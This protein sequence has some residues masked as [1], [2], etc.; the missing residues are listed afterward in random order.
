MDK[1]GELAAAKGVK[2]SQLALAWV[3]AQGDDLIPIPA[4]SSGATWR[5][6]SPRRNCA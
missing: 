2:P 6:T 3:L 1:V 4:P 5:R